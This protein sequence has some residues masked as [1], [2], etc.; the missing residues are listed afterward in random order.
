MGSLIYFFYLS[1]YFLRF[2]GSHCLTFI[3]CNHQR[4][5]YSH[6]LIKIE[7]KTFEIYCL[8]NIN[9]SFVLILGTPFIKEVCYKDLSTG[10]TTHIQYA[11]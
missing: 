8:F 5:V 9:F 10:S 6:I 3:H 2:L 11:I 7:L 1:H 4:G